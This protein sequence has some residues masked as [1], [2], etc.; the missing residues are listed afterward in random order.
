VAAQLP[1]EIFE[2]EKL[3]DQTTLILAKALADQAEANKIQ[4]S[5]NDKYAE[6]FKS[7]S[8]ILER[9]ESK[10]AGKETQTIIAEKVK[11]G[12]ISLGDIRKEVT[13]L[14]E[15]QTLAIEEIRDRFEELQSHKNVPSKDVR[16]KGRQNDESA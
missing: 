16:K 11:R 3:P 12:E 7:I 13:T 14:V 9:I 6:G 1:E 10:M 5:A 15:R 8:I 4:A 2:A